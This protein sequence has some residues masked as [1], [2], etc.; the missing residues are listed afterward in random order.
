[1]ILGVGNREAWQ[2]HVSR[3]R[4]RSR[5]A[6]RRL[7]GRLLARII[8]RVLLRRAPSASSPRRQREVVRRADARPARGAG[9][10]PSTSRARPSSVAAGEGRVGRVDA[11]VEHRPAQRAAGE[12]EQ[13]R[14][15]VGLDGHARAPDGGARRAVAVDRPQQRWQVVLSRSRPVSRSRAASTSSS[16]VRPG[17]G[18]SSSEASPIAGLA[19]TLPLD[20]AHEPDE[21]H[22]RARDLV[23]DGALA[24]LAH[25]V[26]EPLDD[27]VADALSSTAA[28][29]VAPRRPEVLAPP[30]RGRERSTAISSKVSTRGDVGLVVG[31]LHLA[32]ATRSP[33]GTIFSARASCPALGARGG[34][35]RAAGRGAPRG[36]RPR[37][38]P[39][40][41]HHR[42]VLGEALE[43]AL[44][45]RPRAR[46]AGSSSLTPRRL[47]PW[48]RE[49]RRERA[50]RRVD[51]AGARRRWWRSPS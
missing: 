12:A 32:P 5:A 41:R 13:P 17:G 29:S 39:D 47:R 30:L 20:P 48:D 6:A 51:W 44:S 4:G 7:V 8:E 37:G 11:G 38:H 2:Q 25:R 23:A 27:L 43:L 18:S 14:G 33:S 22:E 46:A 40:V 9:G 24:L 16:S 10:R 19:V 3:P 28:T 34:A 45:R 35:A 49:S 1:M 31:Q 36:R 26:L 21:P 42:R 50:A 15:G